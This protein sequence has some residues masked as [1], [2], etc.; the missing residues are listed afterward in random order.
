M[1]LTM[2]ITCHP[3]VEKSQWNVALADEKKEF[4]NEDVILQQ[5]SYL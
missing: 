1:Q 2:A 3:S 4:S 5:F